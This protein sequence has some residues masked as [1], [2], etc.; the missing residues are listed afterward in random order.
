MATATAK[1]TKI[2][3]TNKSSIRLEAPK[4]FQTISVGNVEKEEDRNLISFFY[5]LSKNSFTD[6]GILPLDGTGVLSY[7]H[8]L[9]ATQIVFQ[10]KPGLYHISWGASESTRNKPVYVLAQPWRVWI[11][12]LID[13]ELLGIRHFYSPIQVQSPDQQLYHVNLPNLNCKGYGGTSVGWICLYHNHSWG[14]IPIGNKI[15][16][17][18]ELAGG[19]ESYNDANMSGTDGPRF[20]H[21]NGKP[22]YTYD[23][24]TW[25]AKS[26]AE[27]FE[28]TL[29]LDLWIPILVTGVDDQD[30]HNPEGVPLTLDMA[31]KGNYKAYYSD[32]HQPKPYN[33][34]TRIDVDAPDADKIMQTIDSAFKQAKKD[35]PG[36]A[37]VVQQAANILTNP[38]AVI[39]GYCNQCENPIYN[40][41]HTAHDYE[42]I[43]CAKC[44]APYFAECA[45]CETA[46]HYD[47]LN[48]YAPEEK[49]F[50]V[51][52][53]PIVFCNNCGTPHDTVNNIIGDMFCTMCA[54]ENSYGQCHM[55][56]KNIFTN[57]ITEINALDENDQEK[58]YTLCDTCAPETVICGC[59]YLRSNQVIVTV[60]ADSN[61]MCCQPCTAISSETGVAIYRNPKY[62]PAGISAI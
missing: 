34:F 33:G 15:Q 58:Q 4:A 55:C 59:G 2:T 39:H 43:W 7:R 17:L 36:G 5:E 32:P 57:W 37:E 1:G 28:W 12:D 31:M 56:D 53:K 47:T 62:L 45:Q 30:Q 3:K 24:K 35:L 6:T 41:E 54:E 61:K 60:D 51:N 52:C 16:K 44:A 9:N 21:Q 49:Y 19:F 11:A 20:Y 46:Y 26:E 50:C 25:E 8:A 27:G 42:G 14:D 13:G 22:Q 29:D 38:G 18:I 10:H 23:P 40:L 48:Y